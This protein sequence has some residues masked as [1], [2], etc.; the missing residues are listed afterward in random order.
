MGLTWLT[1]LLERFAD[2]S[3]TIRWPSSAAQPLASRARVFRGRLQSITWQKTPFPP[4]DCFFPGSGMHS[5]LFISAFSFHL[6]LFCGQQVFFRPRKQLGC[7]HH[8]R[9]MSG[10]QQQSRSGLG[11]DNPWLSCWRRSWGRRMGDDHHHLLPQ[12]PPVS[13]LGLPLTA[14]S[15]RMVWPKLA[16]MFLPC[17]VPTGFFTRRLGTSSPGAGDPAEGNLLTPAGQTWPPSQGCT[18]PLPCARL[19]PT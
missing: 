15:P 6:D 11:Q 7:I 1:W 16:G 19:P 9:E 14:S 13:P 3:M 4:K 8:A 17:M 2:L 18:W 10:E 5:Q 12:S